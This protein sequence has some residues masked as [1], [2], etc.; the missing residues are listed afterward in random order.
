MMMRWGAV[1]FENR[2]LLQVFLEK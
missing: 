2:M 1:S